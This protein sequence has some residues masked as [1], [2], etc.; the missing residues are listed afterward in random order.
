VPGQ[1]SIQIAVPRRLW[2]ALGLFA[3]LMLGLLATQVVLIADQ[4][5]TV[6]TQRAI[7]QGQ[8]ARAFPLLDA[9]QPLVRDVHG[10]LPQARALGRRGGRLVRETSGLVADVRS[11]NPAA[12]L[13]ATIA[14][15]DTLLRADVGTATRDVTRLSEAML[16]QDV[17]G[18]V[19]A[20]GTELEY[21]RRLRRLLRGSLGALR[22]MR[23]RD[24]LRKGAR[25]AGSVVR[26][27][28]M[29]R[30]VLKTQVQ[31]FRILEQSLAIQRETERHAE[32]LD[33]KTGPSAAPPAAPL[34]SG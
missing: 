2:M 30:Q 15:A 25:A 28:R 4:D 9:L 11:A 13:Q 8:A 24:V 17:A 32:S 26:V 27:E 14:L 16:G 1:D 20:I 18:H 10:S 21:R 34:P 22:E 6:R 29:T 12:A 19:N 7:A 3:V 23:Q 5:R 33:N 31:A